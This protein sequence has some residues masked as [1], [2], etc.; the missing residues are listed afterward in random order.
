MDRELFF[1]SNSARK[2]YAINIG[3]CVCVCVCACMCVCVCVYVY[4]YVCVFVILVNKGSDLN[5]VNSSASVHLIIL[6]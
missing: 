1:L 5:C 4:V 6:T 2:G 3:V